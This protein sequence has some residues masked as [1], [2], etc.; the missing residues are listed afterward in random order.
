MSYTYEF[1]IIYKYILIE[2]SYVKIPMYLQ[3]VKK[4]D[5]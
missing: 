5:F 3:P 4:I 2:N 1:C